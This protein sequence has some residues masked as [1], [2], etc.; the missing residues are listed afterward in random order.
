MMGRKT[1]V[2]IVFLIKERKSVLNHAMNLFSILISFSLLSS[3]ASQ[4]PSLN[5]K[6]FIGYYG[7]VSDAALTIHESIYCLKQQWYPVSPPELQI[8]L[9]YALAF[10]SHTGHMRLPNPIND[11]VF[12]CFIF[13]IFFQEGVMKTG[14]K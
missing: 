13:I 1:A 10:I 2:Q 4:M 11:N 7:T 6:A 3:Q 8:L 9:Y 14:E 5:P 12:H